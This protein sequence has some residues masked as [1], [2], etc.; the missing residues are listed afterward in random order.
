MRRNRYVACAASAVGLNGPKLSIVVFG[1]TGYIGRAVVEELLARGHAVIAFTRE[2]SGIKGEDTFADVQASFG[3]K[4][5]ISV[6][7]GDVN[8]ETSIT[9]ALMRYEKIDGV[10]CC[11]ASR[12]GGRQ[13]SFDIDYQATINCHAAAKAVK[14]SQFVLLS[15]ICVQK[16]LLAFQ[17]AKLKA[18]AHLKEESRDMAYSIVQPTAF[19]KSLLG[20]VKAVKGG[21]PYVMFGDG[22]IACKPISE[23]DLAAFIA[24]CFW[25]PAKRNATLPI[26]GPGKAMTFKEQGTL[27]FELQGK[28]PSLISVPVALFDLI[29][30]L[31]DFIAGLWPEKFADIAEYGKIGKYY[32]TECMLVLDKETG[33]YREDLTPSYG[34]TTLKAFLTEALQQGSTKLESQQLGA[35]GVGERFGMK[36]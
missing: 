36:D 2:K 7:A 10:V 22:S 9:S 3:S 12:S 1:A 18:E 30:G 29:N 21:S 26:G 27:L 20:Q 33:T 4:G 6:V 32:A 15:A 16:P 35:Q 19:F 5:D 25:D 14:A 24:D 31:L 17:E 8:S 34:R 11:L 13:D 23:E 28:E